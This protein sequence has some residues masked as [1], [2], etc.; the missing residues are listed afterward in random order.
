MLHV[1]HEGVQ[2]IPVLV[3]VHLP[4]LQSLVVHPQAEQVMVVR[5]L[6][7]RK[8]TRSRTRS[9]RGV[10]VVGRETGEEQKKQRKDSCSYYKGERHHFSVGTAYVSRMIGA[11]RGAESNRTKQ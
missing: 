3:R 9:R 7:T 1:V 11:A 8:R 4:G 2:L 5:V 6:M 10:R